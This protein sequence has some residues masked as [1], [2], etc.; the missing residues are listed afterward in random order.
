MKFLLDVNASGAVE[1]ILKATGHD[2]KLVADKDIRMPDN[3]ILQ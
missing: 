3:D 2:V 1:K